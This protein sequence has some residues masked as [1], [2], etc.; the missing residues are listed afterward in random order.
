[1]QNLWVVAIVG[2]V[3]APISAIFSYPSMV[4]SKPPDW[5]RPWFLFGVTFQNT[6][7]LPLVLIQTIC[8]QI[9]SPLRD[10]SGT[11]VTEGNGT[12]VWM[13]IQECVTQGNLYIFMYIFLHSLLFWVVAYDLM[14]NKKLAERDSS[15]EADVEDVVVQET[16]DEKKASSSSR[17]IHSVG[18]GEDHAEASL[19]LGDSRSISTINDINGALAPFPNLS[20]NSP[21]LHN[22]HTESHDPVS[23][24]MTSS[25]AATL[26]ASPRASRMSKLA[27][28]HDYVA[29]SFYG[30]A[31]QIEGM[32]QVGNNNMP[33]RPKTFLNKARARLIWLFFH[34]ISLC[35]RPPIIAQLL[36][37]FIGL[38]KP[39]QDAFFA[40]ASV[41][42]P[43]TL[44]IKI[45][46]VASTA[47]TNL[48]MSGGLGLKMR[49]IQPRH[50]FG[51][52]PN[53]LSRRAT[54]GFVVT[55]M[56]VIPAALFGLTYLLQVTKLVPNDRLLLMVLYMQTMT[57][58]ANMC[59]VVPQILGDHQAS[60]ALSL[61][62]LSQYIVALPTMLLWLSL[63]FWVT[64][65]I[66]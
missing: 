23:V 43:V 31:E 46:A 57:P 64:S 66:L 14:P 63:A 50:L 15:N 38:I 35:A 58:S 54:I 28:T 48:S 7:A 62:V 53:G 20:E 44:S 5:F 59:V 24:Y 19:P 9:R 27:E 34:T 55:R 60:G 16:P 32:R 12:I 65:D 52:D 29:G 3:T 40:P 4:L 22:D 42:R 30:G 10:Q 61:L 6:V 45:F 36:G 49:E 47:V 39:L 33:K 26:H 8:S 17:E 21:N 18:T 56:L 2:V 51:G 41:L 13:D 37:M 11:I 1:L 25:L